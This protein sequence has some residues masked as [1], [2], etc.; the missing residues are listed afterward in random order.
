MRRLIQGEAMLASAEA[1]QEFPL[2]IEALEPIPTPVEAATHLKRARGRPA[3]IAAE[4]KEQARKV[5]ANGGTNRDA[6]A[7]LYGV[8]YPTPQQVKNVCSLLR[9]RKPNRTS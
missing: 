9:K 4:L 8:K 2:P 7:M 5:K 3:K 1:L 6:A